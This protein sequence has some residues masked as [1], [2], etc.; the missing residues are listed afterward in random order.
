M[1]IELETTI[2]NE[3]GLGAHFNWFNGSGSCE[4]IRNEA[5]KRLTEVINRYAGK[6][7]APANSELISIAKEVARTEGSRYTLTKTW[8]VCSYVIQA[9]IYMAANENKM[10]IARQWESDLRKQ[11]LPNNVCDFFKYGHCARCDH[12]CREYFDMGGWKNY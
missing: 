6:E 3:I 5:A 12:P 9:H 11:Y 1:A 10:A 4:H 2:M 7:I 8:E